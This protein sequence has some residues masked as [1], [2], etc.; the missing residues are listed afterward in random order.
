VEKDK[1]CIVRYKEFGEDWEFEGN[2]N[3]FVNMS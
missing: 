1:K 2:D 3:Y